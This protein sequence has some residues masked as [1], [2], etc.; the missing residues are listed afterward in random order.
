MEG[1]QGS[2]LGKDEKLI[3]QLYVGSVQATTG[4]RTGI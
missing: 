4:V 2:L 3:S 1:E